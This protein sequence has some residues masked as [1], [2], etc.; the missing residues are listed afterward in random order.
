[1]VRNQPGDIT[2]GNRLFRFISLEWVPVTTALVSLMFS[3]S[4]IFI[5]TRDPAVV[6]I[7]PDQVRVAQGEDFGFAYL[8]VQPAFVNTGRNE[9]VEVIRDMKLHIAAAAGGQPAEFVWANQAELVYD[10][11][12][13]QLNY[14]YVAD[15]VPLVVSPRSA[16]VPFSVFN[17]PKGWYFSPGVYRLRLSAQRVVSRRPLQETVEIAFGDKDVDFLNKSRG[18]SF[19]VFPVKKP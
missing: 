9:R 16:Q 1:V 5:S 4:S 14:R 12:T 10:R 18:G 13:N 15:A 17:G 3:V 19:L 8:Y 2:S 11:A 6:M 7:L